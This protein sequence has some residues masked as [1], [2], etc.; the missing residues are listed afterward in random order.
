MD[1]LNLYAFASEN[2][3]TKCDYEALQFYLMKIKINNERI[4]ERFL[5]FLE[6]EQLRSPE[7]KKI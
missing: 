4:L 1:G 2:P 6:K 5:L 7:I 3:T